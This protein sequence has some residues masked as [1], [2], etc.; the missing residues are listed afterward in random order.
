M[1]YA[2]IKTLK[3]SA[4][5]VTSALF[6]EMRNSILQLG[7]VPAQLSM[8]IRMAK[9]TNL[10]TGQTNSAKIKRMAQSVIAILPGC[11]LKFIIVHFPFW[12]PCLYH[13]TDR[14][15]GVINSLDTWVQIKFASISSDPAMHVVVLCSFQF[16]IK[17]NLSA[18]THLYDINRK[19]QYLRSP[20]LSY[21]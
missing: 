16:L 17:S 6:C 12:K 4:I 14:I 3:A 5:Y 7:E 9:N 8:I 15:A 18:Q 10:A 19:L 2:V 11:R 1:K 21:I 20:A 13:F